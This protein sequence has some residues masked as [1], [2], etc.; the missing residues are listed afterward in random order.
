V[1]QAYHAATAA[2][3]IA[4]HQ[5]FKVP[6]SK[7]KVSNTL[8]PTPD[9]LSSSLGTGHSTLNTEAEAEAGFLK[10][11]DIAQKQQAKS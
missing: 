7:F 9:T 6:S 10:A 1:V 8:L 3:I 11:I 2:A 5:Q 4:K